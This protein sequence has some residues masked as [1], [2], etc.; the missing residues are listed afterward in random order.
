MIAV[1][2]CR[3][4]DFLG[5]AVIKVALTFGPAD[6]L[7][8]TFRFHF[9]VTC[10]W[11][12]VRSIFR[13]YFESDRFTNVVVTLFHFKLGIQI[14]AVNTQQSWP[15]PTSRILLNV[16]NDFVKRILLNTHMCH[17]FFTSFEGS[18]MTLSKSGIASFKQDMRKLQVG[19]R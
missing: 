13:D 11:L 15:G 2:T 18:N 10:K 9:E 12:S 4:F 17:V 16:V 1:I 7:R 5:R 3:T 14:W 19:T 6:L 8:P